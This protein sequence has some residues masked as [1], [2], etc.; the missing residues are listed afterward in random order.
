L[1][2][3]FSTILGPDMFGIR[4]L[5]VSKRIIRCSVKLI[6]QMALRCPVGIQSRMLRTLVQCL[7]EAP[8]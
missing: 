5:F 7:P 4:L 1:W 8:G 2:V 6:A 3:P